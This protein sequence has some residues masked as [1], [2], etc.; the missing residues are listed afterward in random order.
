M[1][2]QYQS[3]AFGVTSDFGLLRSYEVAL[4]SALRFVAAVQNLPYNT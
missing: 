2:L 4:A 1:S 3:T